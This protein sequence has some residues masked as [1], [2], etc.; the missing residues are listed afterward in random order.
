MLQL[1]SVGLW[2]GS[3]VSGGRENCSVRGVG[4]FAVIGEFEAEGELVGGDVV[5]IT[6]CLV[7]V[8]LDDTFSASTTFGRTESPIV[9]RE[10]ERKKKKYE[11]RSD[12]CS[13]KSYG[14]DFVLFCDGSAGVMQLVFLLDSCIMND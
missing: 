10:K 8:S 13:C 4:V 1:S 2:G 7:K 14:L 9:R 3:G 5:S 12:S 6:C 11:T